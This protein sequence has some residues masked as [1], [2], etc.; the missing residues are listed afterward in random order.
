VRGEQRD[1]DDVEQRHR[2]SD[3]RTIPQSV[4]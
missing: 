3:S 4:G 1:R 2:Q